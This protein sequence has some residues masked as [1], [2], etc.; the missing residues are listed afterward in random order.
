M[1]RRNNDETIIIISFFHHTKI[2]VVVEVLCSA[3]V[4]VI[5]SL[6]YHVGYYM[7]CIR[8]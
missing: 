3:V 7:R 1:L 4:R 8:S 5:A 2:V 6:D